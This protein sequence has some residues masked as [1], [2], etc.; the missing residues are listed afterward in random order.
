MESKMEW[1]EFTETS[2]LD[3]ILLTLDSNEFLDD[4]GSPDDDSG[5][6]TKRRKRRQYV[7]LKDS[8]S[9]HIN[10]ASAN[11]YRIRIPKVPSEDIRR[12]YPIM[13][14]NT[15]NSLDTSL[16]HAFFHQFT[17]PESAL[18]RQ[19]FNANEPDQEIQRISFYGADNI[20][21]Y[22]FATTLINTDRVLRAHDIKIITRSDTFRTEIV[23][24]GEGSATWIYDTD[25][26]KI[27]HFL[28]YIFLE[29]TQ[30]LKRPCSDISGLERLYNRQHLRLAKKPIQINGK[31]RITLVIN[32]IRERQTIDE[33][34]FASYGVPQSAIPIQPVES[35]LLN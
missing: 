32:D 7:K 33:I 34:Y 20:F 16:M 15:L 2:I 28:Q 27:G 4:N 30:E 12:K 24:D 1:G 26:I 35:K 18:Q 11:P 22:M 3:S 10:N 13:I 21:S 25:P 8:R 17:H 19:V 14:M 29:T 23:I 6:Q 9:F 31:G 5:R